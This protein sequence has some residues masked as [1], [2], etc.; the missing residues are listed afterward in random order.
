MFARK[1]EPTQ[2]KVLHSRVDQSFHKYKNRLGCLP[3]LK[4]LGYK[5]KIVDYS[6]KSS[7]ETDTVRTFFFVYFSLKNMD[8]VQ[9]F[10]K[11]P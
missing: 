11:A 8:L 5:S 9:P 2:V 6:K 1:A 4:S 7:I 10:Q 3:E